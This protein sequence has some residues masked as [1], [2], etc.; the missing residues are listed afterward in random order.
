MYLDIY[1]ASERSAKV[2]T[3]SCTDIC[4][5]GDNEASDIFIWNV[6]KLVSLIGRGP[7]NMD[8]DPQYGWRRMDLWYMDLE[9][10]RRVTT[11]FNLMTKYF[12]CEADLWGNVYFITTIFA[13]GAH[14]H[15][16]YSTINVASTWRRGPAF[17][18]ARDAGQLLFIYCAG[19]R[20]E[21]LHC[22][23]STVLLPCPRALC[24]A[25]P[26]RGLLNSLTPRRRAEGETFIPRI[27]RSHG[28][29]N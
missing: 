29:D 12:F 14:R 19:L 17:C 25:G 16:I 8:C 5:S 27:M 7:H 6:T 10:G 24:P 21:S 15:N 4:N 22:P 18:V 1:A 26:G 11:L 20:L 2:Q 3:S 13:A 9:Q 28:S 23:P